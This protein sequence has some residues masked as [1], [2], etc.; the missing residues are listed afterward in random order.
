MADDGDEGDDGSTDILIGAAVR[1]C[2]AF[3]PCRVLTDLI[4]ALILLDVFH[5]IVCRGG[6]RVRQACRRSCTVKRIVY[7]NTGYMMAGIIDD[8]E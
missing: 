4:L 7:T 6:H 2:R 5:D 3:V 1:T 8:C